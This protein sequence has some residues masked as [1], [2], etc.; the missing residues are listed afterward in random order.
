MNKKL[1]IKLIKITLIIIWMI[2]VF[3]FSSENGE[4]SETTSKKVTKVVIGVVGDNEEKKNETEIKKVDKKIRKLAHYTIY[5][6]GGILII[7]YFQ[8]T[9]KELREKVIYSVAIGAG[10]AVT[11]EL[12]QLLVSERTARLL[13]VGIDTLGIIT[14]VILYL[15]VIKEYKKIKGE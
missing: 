15:M 7:S 12:H 8:T 4:K 10:Y 9:K 1:I 14:G 5:T 6:V 13:D 11:D 2:T 3:L